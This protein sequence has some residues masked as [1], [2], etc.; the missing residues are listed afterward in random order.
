MSLQEL[1]VQESK[2]D[3]I[4]DNIENIEPVSVYKQDEP[5]TFPVNILEK[6]FAKED[7]IL[8]LQPLDWYLLSMTNMKHD[9]IW[10]LNP[11]LFLLWSNDMFS[12]CF[13][14]FSLT[15]LMIIEVDVH[16]QSWLARHRLFSILLF[17]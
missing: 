9:D 1:I 12:H 14:T 8:K 4:D 13:P 2:I 10:F 6:L 15:L 16:S 11:D 7:N 3:W 5:E 17:F